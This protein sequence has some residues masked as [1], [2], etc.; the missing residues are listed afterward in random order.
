MM[1]QH[2]AKQHLRQHWITSM[3]LESTK[4]FHGLFAFEY[5][6][7]CPREVVIL[8]QRFARNIFRASELFT[9]RALQSLGAGVALGTIYMNISGGSRMATEADR[10]GFFAFTL[11]FLFSSTMEALPIFL[12]ERDIVE[13]E[14]RRGAYRVCSYV[15]ANVFV[16]LP[17]L[18]L[19]AMLYAMGAYWLVGVKGPMPLT[20]DPEAFGFFVLVLWLA[21][22][23]ANS[24]LSFVV[25][26]VPDYIVGNSIIATC[27]GFF[28]LFSGYFIS[29]SNMPTYWRFMHYISLFKY[30]LDALLVNEFGSSSDGETRC[31]ATSNYGSN[32]FCILS[33]ENILT[34]LG[35]QYTS[36]WQSVSVMISF[37]CLY[38]FL[39]YFMLLLKVW[40]ATTKS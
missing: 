39:G 15:M 36:K 40:R 31:F 25:T 6:N 32:S 20:R 27:F 5:N 37:A 8:T 30:P 29:L 2:G 10:L 33:G 4:L 35:L 7:G 21:L 9:Q 23:L 16:F 34:E 18:L 22:T 12:R 13:M 26:L 3:S 17:F 1:A 28:F 11:T 14:S 38:R 19:L 24:F